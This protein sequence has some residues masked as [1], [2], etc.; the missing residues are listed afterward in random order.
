MRLVCA[1]IPTQTCALL[2]F[3]SCLPWQPV[4]LPPMFSQEEAPG[5][6]HRAH[7]P[8]LKISVF[9]PLAL[10]LDHN[11]LSLPDVPLQFL[12]VGNFRDLFSFLGQDDVEK[13]DGF[14]T[15]PLWWPHNCKTTYLPANQP[16][17]SF[18]LPVPPSLLLL[19]LAGEGEGGQRERGESFP[20]LR[21]KLLK[22][23]QL[24]LPFPAF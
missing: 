14:K 22:S 5:S 16:M 23:D 11:Q 18:D 13:P 1:L 4:R 6:S 24:T 17:A 21:R 15:C 12:G 8:L 10:S 19:F 3:Q 9:S 2:S 20:P 7:L